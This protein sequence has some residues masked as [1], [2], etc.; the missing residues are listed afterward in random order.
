M[1]EFYSIMKTNKARD[2]G[3]GRVF[4]AD[5]CLLTQRGH[6]SPPHDSETMKYTTNCRHTDTTMAIILLDIVARRLN[7]YTHRQ[8]QLKHRKVK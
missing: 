7:R 4:F 1:K 2:T 6:A 5:Y 8:K 3:S